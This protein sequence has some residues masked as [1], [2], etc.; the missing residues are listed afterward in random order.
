MVLIAG[1][2]ALLAQLPLQL[3]ERAAKLLATRGIQLIFDDAVASVDAGGLTLHSGRRIPSR[4]IVWS[5]G[6]R[7]ATLV[8]TLDV[9]HD[10]HDAIA[11]ETDFSVRG[12]DG[13]WA[14]G[15]CA[16]VPKPGGGF[17]PQT[18]QHA[19]HEARHLARNVLARLRGR[20]ATPYRYR[21]R[22]I[23]A[24][25]GHREGLAALGGGITLSG[26]PAWFLWRSNYLTQL[27]GTDRKARVALDW[28]LDLPFPQ[29]IASVR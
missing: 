19:V 3:G 15:D 27:P 21:S 11:I 9:V 25:I 23:M 28:A 12:T 10:G 8:S 22:G 20:R 26:L 14:L 17:Y 16:A 7:P 24:S 13:V 4:C 18:A 5:A 6:V 2:P 1:A 29:D